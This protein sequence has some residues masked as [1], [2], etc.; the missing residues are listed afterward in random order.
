MGVKW[1]ASA[2]NMILKGIGV[3]LK[4][5]IGQGWLGAERRMGR[6]VE[7]VGEEAIRLRAGEDGAPLTMR[8]L[9]G[10]LDAD[11]TLRYLAQTCDMVPGAVTDCQ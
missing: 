8:T 7:R 9:R 2:K 4:K 1:L 5:L 10:M 6:R 3:K 11:R